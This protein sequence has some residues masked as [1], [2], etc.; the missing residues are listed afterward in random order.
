MPTYLAGDPE[1][2]LDCQRG[3]RYMQKEEN[4]DYR[5]TLYNHASLR[6]AERIRGSLFRPLDAHVV[7][8][9]FVTIDGLVFDEQRLYVW[10][11]HIE[12]PS[13]PEIVNRAG[14]AT[15]VF[16]FEEL[17]LFKRS[18]G[19]VS[20]SLE[21]ASG[22]SLLSRFS[23]HPDAYGVLKAGF[24]LSHLNATAKFFNYFDSAPE[25][26]VRVAHH[27]CIISVQQAFALNFAH[28]ME[29][30][31]P[32]IVYTLTNGRLL[33]STREWRCSYLL[34]GAK[35]EEKFVKLLGIAEKRIIHY[36]P[37][38]LYHA[39]KVIVFR[40]LPRDHMLREDA[41]AVSKFL[42]VVCPP[43]LS[44]TKRR[45]L[46]FDGRVTKRSDEDEDEG[47]SDTRVADPDNLNASHY[48]VN[49]EEVRAFL[50]RAAKV[51]GLDFVEYENYKSWSQWDTIQ[52][53]RR[54]EEFVILHGGGTMNTLHAPRC[55]RSIE[56]L[57]SRHP[58]RS[59]GCGISHASFLANSMRH[60]YVSI[61]VSGSILS[62]VTVDVEVLRKAL[63]RARSSKDHGC[64]PL[65]RR[66]FYGHRD[67]EEL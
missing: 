45:A 26:P 52:L 65:K 64:S 35:F 9:G 66:S 54:A 41:M 33:Q 13:F 50:R 61:M 10:E 15:H 62:P 44:E 28:W 42:G 2:A 21:A 17:G 49:I 24:L 55:A 59:Q 34:Y 63:A 18:K 4:S 56:I 46:I 14:L 67:T 29:S 22:H 12:E 19:S 57:P 6:D 7:N 8:N 25:S 48:I 47:E 43:P 1:V 39:D 38:V 31:L 36:D 5:F 16:A 3:D 58:Y 53:F 40:P 23:E 20:L 37:T 30:I 11:K 27:E 51:A 60:P 32:K